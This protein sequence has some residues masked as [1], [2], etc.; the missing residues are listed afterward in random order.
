MIFGMADM[1]IAILEIKCNYL[2]GRKDTM[3]FGITDIIDGW[4]HWYLKDNEKKVE[5]TASR[6]TDED[7]VRR[8]LVSLTGLIRD[9]KEK[10]F[11]IFA[12]PG[13]LTIKMS[14]DRNNNFNL[15]LA[16]EEMSDLMDNMQETKHYYKFVTSMYL[17][18]TEFVPSILKSFNYYERNRVMLD[19]YEVNWTVAIGTNDSEKFS[20]PFD[21]LQKLHQTAS[22]IRIN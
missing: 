14:V 3:E 9:K 17:M 5:I 18:R 4:F 11:E 13:F 6:C 22:D 7:F 16:F 8:F 1:S 12:E 21:E 2:T 20:F 15:E 19:S 10:I